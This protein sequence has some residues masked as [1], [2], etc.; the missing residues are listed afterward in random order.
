ML[1]YLKKFNILGYLLNKDVSQWL[2]EVMKFVFFVGLKF[3]F[4]EFVQ[5]ITQSNCVVFSNYSP[6]PITII[7]QIEF[8]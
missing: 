8:L 4:K 1:K 6:L 7:D 5:W 3:Y 2:L